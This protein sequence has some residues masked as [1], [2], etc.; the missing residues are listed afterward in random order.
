MQKVIEIE[1]G[2][3]RKPE[4]R[5]NIPAK[6]ELLSNEQLAVVGNNASGKSMFIDIITGRHPLLSD[7]SL[8]Y[9]FSPSKKEYA[10]DNIKYIKF[11]DSYGTDTDRNY[12]MQQRWNQGEIGDS[13]ITVAE[14]LKT[15][16]GDI[17]EKINTSDNSYYKQLFDLFSLE[18]IMEKRIISLSSGEL[19]RLIL[20]LSI[21]NHPRI[22]IIDNPFIGLDAQTR[23]LLKDFMNTLCKTQTIQLILVLTDEKEIPDFITHVVEVSNMSVKQKQIRGDY[24]AKH[25]KTQEDILDETTRN[26]IINLPYSM[27]SESYSYEYAIRMHNICIRYGNNTILN[28][29]DWAVRNGEHW[30]ITGRNGSG[31]STLLSIVC[32]DNPQSYACDVELF[33]K[34]RGSGES[35]WEIKKHIGYVSPEMHRAFKQNIPAINIVHSGFHNSIGQKI[36][37]SKESLASCQFW[38]KVFGIESLTERTFFNMSSGEQRLVLLARAF[39]NDPELLILDEPLHG[40]DHRNKIMV[41]DII[42]AFCKRKNKT[43]I[44]VTHYKD[45][46][47]R[48]IDK[49]LNLTKA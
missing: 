13:I 28:K 4:W 9:D 10:S 26:A 39:V 35:I 33:D 29:I 30:S 32:A 43:L 18:A 48:C 16:Y 3:T 38:M 1:D 49:E 46:L 14:K 34:K 27:D 11:K 23:E 31:K 41:N 22:L 42:E 44:V 21:L 8:K 47:P 15:E 2:I 20:F 17:I 5:M 37:M 24:M 7:N 12:Y 45:E 19:R 6:F 36:R 25:I 40:L